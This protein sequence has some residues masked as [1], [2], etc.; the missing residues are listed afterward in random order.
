MIA[1]VGSSSGMCSDSDDAGRRQKKRRKKRGE[2]SLGLEG[3]R[4]DMF[5]F[6][7]GTGGTVVAR[8]IFELPHIRRNAFCHDLIIFHCDL[9]VV[10]AANS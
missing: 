10:G 3:L 8:L 6:S 1:A 5:F 7:H 2:K 9:R 4:D